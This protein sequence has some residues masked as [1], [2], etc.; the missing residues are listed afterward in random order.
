MEY[1]KTTAKCLECGITFEYA[2][3]DEEMEDESAMDIPCPIC[4]ELADFEPYTPC[5]EDEY[6]E[7]IESYEEEMEE[8]FE[9]EE[10]DW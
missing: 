6:E 2:V 10:F 8:G 5:T 7:I 4:G 9:F 3:T 1:F